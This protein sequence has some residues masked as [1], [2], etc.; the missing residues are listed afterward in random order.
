MLFKLISSGLRESL[1]NSGVQEAVRSPAIDVLDRFLINQFQH[2]EIFELLD[3]LGSPREAVCQW[4]VDNFHSFIKPLIPST[5]PRTLQEKTW[6]TFTYTC[7]ALGV[8][9]CLLVI[10]SSYAVYKR[11]NHRVM[12]YAQIEFL[13]ILLFG[14]L[15]VGIGATLRALPPSDALCIV[16]AWLVTFGQT[17]VLVPLMVKVAAI[18]RL[19]Q[20]SRRMKRVTIKRKSLLGITASVSALIVVFLVC[21]TVIDPPKKTSEYELT[22][23]LTEDGYTVVFASY[24][25][26]SISDIWRYVSVCWNAVLLMCS[27]VLAFQTRSIRQE[28]NESQVLTALIYTH[29][30]VALLQ[31]ITFFLSTAVNPASLQMVRSSK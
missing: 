6:P 18:N 8:S 4:A 2:G 5:H 17:L 24:Y 30:A 11:R 27:A 16:A 7:L 31:V 26:S 14:G 12:Q 3:Q 10:A 13:W 9:S 23:N 20:A 15:L 21:M 28:F 1:Q 25:C 22:R 19:M 29:F